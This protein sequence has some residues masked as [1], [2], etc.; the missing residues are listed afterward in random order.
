MASSAMELYL[1]VLGFLP[2]THTETNANKMCPGSSPVVWCFTRDY[3][4]AQT[5]EHTHLTNSY[6]D[7]EK[8]WNTTQLEPYARIKM[9]LVLGSPVYIWWYL[10]VI[11]TTYV[12]GYK[13]FG[14]SGW[15]NWSS[16]IIKIF[17]PLQSQ[18]FIICILF[19]TSIH[20]TYPILTSYQ[21]RH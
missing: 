15:A 21:W 20:V 13:Y 14:G 16:D 7:R 3:L 1:G 11:R 4:H 18:A 8:T 2:T 6:F 5:A 9:A 19:C 12:K 17:V 10:C